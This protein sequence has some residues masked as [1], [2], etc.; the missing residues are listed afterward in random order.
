M[1]VPLLVPDASV[2]L[3]WVL[4]SDDEENRDCAA[5][6]RHSW[7]SGSCTIVVPSL[8]AFEVGNIIGMKE[9]R[10]GGELMGILIEYGFEEEPPEAFYKKALGLMRDFKVT[11][12]DAA[13]HA[14]ALNRSGTFITADADYVRKTS[15]A[16]HVMRLAD[17]SGSK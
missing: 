15:R 8:W 17:W 6:I 5:E 14:I 2:L 12:Y 16:G 1:T 7:L 13:Y 3:K 4:E 10:L 11:F 9:P